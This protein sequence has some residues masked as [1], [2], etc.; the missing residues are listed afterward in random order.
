MRFRVVGSSSTRRTLG[1]ARNGRPVRPEMSSRRRAVARI[2]SSTS[3]GVIP[4]VPTPPARFKSAFS[5]TR[6]WTWTAAI[7]ASIVRCCPI[8]RTASSMSWAILSIGP[9]AVHGSCPFSLGGDGFPE[10]SPRRRIA[11]RGGLGPTIP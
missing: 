3:A 4:P 9:G 10:S 6:A 5:S 7:W 8:R 1:V 11:Y 2:S